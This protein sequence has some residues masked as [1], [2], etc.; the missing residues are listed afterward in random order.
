M[1]EFAGAWSADGSQILIG[2]QDLVGDGGSRV[3]IR[4]ATD[5]KARLLPGPPRYTMT[6]V[7][8]GDG[9]RIAVATGGPNG[10]ALQRIEVPLL[11][12]P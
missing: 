12:S 8:F 11:K 4:S 3:D 6:L 10:S 7:G 9:D 1:Y 5:G 2:W